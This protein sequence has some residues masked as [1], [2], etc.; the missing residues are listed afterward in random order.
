[1]RT[2]PTISEVIQAELAAEAKAT[3]GM[4]SVSLADYRAGKAPRHVQFYLW[5]RGKLSEAGSVSEDLW[6]TCPRENGGFGLSYC[7]HGGTRLYYRPVP[8]L[9]VRV[10]VKDCYLAVANEDPS[11][12]LMSWE[13]SADAL[14]RIRRWA[15]VNGFE[16]VGGDP[17]PVRN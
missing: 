15:S 2:Y 8:P 11:Q 12:A 13:F 4:E 14:D 17:E 1:M 5:A 7:C 6:V 10:L 16:I 3:E 9:K